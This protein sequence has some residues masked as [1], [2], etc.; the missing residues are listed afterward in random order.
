MSQPTTD[1]QTIRNKVRALTANPSPQQLSDATIDQ[2]INTY[3][4]YDLPD[5][6]R[7]FNLKTVYSF[8]TQP[9][10]DVYTLP[11]DLYTSFHPPLYVA[12]YYCKYTQSRSE[13]FQ[14]YPEILQNSVLGS[15]NGTAGP[16]TFTLTNA[17]VAR[18]SV[19]IAGID[20]N[21]FSWNL[22]D[23]GAGNLVGG[24]S[25]T[26]DYLTGVATFTFGGVIPASENITGNFYFYQPSR[27]QCGMVYQDSITLRPIPDQAYQVQ[28]DAYILPTALLTVNQDP[29][30]KQV[31]QLLA[32]GAALKILE[33]RNDV[34]N[35]A[36]VAEILKKYEYEAV[37]RTSVQRSNQRVATIY[38]QQV[39]FGWGAGAGWMGQ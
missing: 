12:G 18:N 15:G 29:F 22:T 9:N 13:L 3:Y 8:T 17:P 26:V 7:L 33:D 36:F 23:D 21:N 6:L 24:G 30:L 20:A 35:Y 34:E 11:I 4:L 1:L 19:L 16:Y 5:Q 39:Q 37:Y 2:Y 10:I 27:P 38:T 31:W 28:L 14:I 25:G 32:C